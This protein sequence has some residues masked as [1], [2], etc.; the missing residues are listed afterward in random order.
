MIIKF[1]NLLLKNQQYSNQTTCWNVRQ[2]SLWEELNSPL[3]FYSQRYAICT[4]DSAT[5]SVTF[6]VSLQ[7]LSQLFIRYFTLEFNSSLTFLSISHIH[8]KNDFLL[9]NIWDLQLCQFFPTILIAITIVN[10]T[11]SFPFCFSQ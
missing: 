9:D 6:V 3:E 4:F 2:R 7:L 8:T 10:A 1:H 11:V 5:P